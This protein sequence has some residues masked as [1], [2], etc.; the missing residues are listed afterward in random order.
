M[1]ETLV[2][3]GV[4]EP[5]IER[6]VLVRERVNSILFFVRR[7]R[8]GACDSVLER[9]SISSYFVAPQREQTSVVT[10]S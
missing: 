8:T 1:P 9:I 5:E 2:M 6:L 7:F 10:V 4:A 3:T